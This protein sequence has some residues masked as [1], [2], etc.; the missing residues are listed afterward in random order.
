MH[1]ERRSSS[2]DCPE[3]NSAG[4]EL[5]DSD[6]EESNGVSTATC[7]YGDETEPCTYLNGVFEIGPDNCPGAPASSVGGNFTPAKT[8]TDIFTQTQTLIQTTNG[9]TSTPS[10]QGVTSPGSAASISPSKIS[11]P[12]SSSSSLSASASAPPSEPASSSSTSA[13]LSPGTAAGIAISAIAVVVLAV[14][15]AFCIIRDR[16]RRRRSRSGANPEKALTSLPTPS[17]VLTPFPLR[18]GRADSA[19]R[20]SH[21]ASAPSTSSPS[22]DV[23]SS[24]LVA[25][26]TA[27][28]K[29]LE[30]TQGRHSEQ[31]A[32]NDVLRE[33]VRVLEQELHYRRE[34]VEFSEMS[35]PVYTPTAVR[36]LPGVPS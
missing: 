17:S 16:R 13:A 19:S 8:V 5:A 35:P 34:D 10:T 12:L 3:T 30:H 11:T 27:V 15:L 6:D 14:L 9:P 22:S 23:R 4:E 32:E 28:R 33:R 20:P 7:T 24:A 26:L 36:S 18:S 31:S 1:L 2:F 29:A 21:S 25:E